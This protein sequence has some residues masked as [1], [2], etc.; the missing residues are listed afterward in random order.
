MQIT[1]RIQQ[2][3]L[4]LLNAAEP[5]SEQNIADTLNVSK[6]T[7]QREFD[8]LSSGVAEYGL[9]LERMKGAGLLLSGSDESK[10]ALRESLTQKTSVDFGDK[11]ERKKYILFELLHDRNPHKLFYYSNQMGVSEATVSTDMEDLRPWLEQNHLSLL[12]KQ[13]YG[14][15]VNGTEANYREAMRRF[16]Q[17]NSNWSVWGAASEEEA[18]AGAIMN[19]AGAGIYSLLDGNMIQRVSSLMN[20]LEEPE[21]K[22]LSQEAYMGLIIHIS[23]ALRRIQEGG[24]VEAEPD[25]LESI[26]SWEGYDLAKRILDELEQEFSLT[27]PKVELSYILLHIQ[28]SRRAYHNNTDRQDPLTMENEALLNLIDKLIDAF[29]PEYA[30]DLKSDEEFV[31]GLLVH[32]RPTLV[33]LQNNMNIINPLLNEVKAEYRSVFDRMAAAVNVITEETGLVLNEDEIG[34]LTVH[35]GAGMLRIR[36]TKTY[37]RKVN[38]GVVC[39]SGFGVSRL[40]MTKLQNELSGQAKLHTYGSTDLTDDVVSEMDFFVSS[41]PVGRTDIDVVDVS[42]LIT[43]K[44]MLHVK[45]KIE[46]YSHVRK[47]VVQNNFFDQLD[48]T[49]TMSLDIKT[50]VNGFHA[51][52]LAPDITLKEGIR[53][54][55]GKAAKGQIISQKIAEAIEARERLSSQVFPELG[56]VLMHCRTDAAREPVFLSATAEGGV[57]FTNEQLKDIKVFLL[58]IAPE[59]Q[60]V[61]IHTD[62]LGSISS[63]LIE[64]PELLQSLVAGNEEETRTI[65]TTVLKDHFSKFIQSI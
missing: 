58:L 19:N 17:E 2:I 32:L 48:S 41:I 62:L 59:D 36:N 11:E 35:F 8:Y 44:D 27:I 43:A 42:P 20:A 57:G 60:Y 28:G 47:D 33:R 22:K 52:T 6:R 25:L 46:E 61:E 64:R 51:Y 37:S 21:L 45:V 53:F 5:L 24:I 30:Y 40:M 9:T 50:L 16:I 1:K 15:V 14:V 18:M 31:R 3:L 26:E 63:A 23:I 55:S 29:D 39:A 10:R 38:I 12:K 49:A 13:G 34:F 54:L 56:I 7:V 4:L 65:L